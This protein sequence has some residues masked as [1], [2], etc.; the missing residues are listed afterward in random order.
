MPAAKVT[1][2]E[3]IRIWNEEKSPQA[4]ADRTGVTLRN[5]Y[6]RRAR[7]VKNGYDLPTRP[8]P[9]YNSYSPYAESGWTFP[10]EKRI[11]VHDGAVVVTSDHHY[12]PG[13]PTVAHRA[14]IEVIKQVKP[15][16]KIVNGDIF[17]GGSIGRHDPFGWSNRPGVK[18]E[19]D[20]CTERL[21]EMEQAVPKGCE[22]LWNLG[23]HCVR[24]ERNLATKVSDYANV[25][26]MRLADHFPAW[27]MQWSTL[28]NADSAHPVMVKHKQAGGVHAGYNNTLK[29]GWT[30][31]TG[32]THQ[33]EAKP[34]VDYRG[35]RW[36]IQ[37]GTLA[38]LH[39]PQF[40]YTENGPSL[41]CPGFVVLTFCDGVLCP[42][43]LCEVIDGR[44]WFR[45]RVVAE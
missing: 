25:I 3:F 14:C 30:M 40:E 36:G 31:V 23:N 26:G 5:A 42:P 44:A 43:E 18:E 20:A 7:M 21:G 13:E 38:D 29:G 37:D 27:E 8:V 41:A 22:L 6:A 28:I 10:R 34:I 4:V 1:D 33:L 2:A 35:R 32:H 17:D 19:L 11:E 16:V 45:G 15:R 24:F 39:S 9:G 12:W